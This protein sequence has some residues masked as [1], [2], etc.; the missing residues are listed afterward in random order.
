M[1]QRH[2]FVPCC[3]CGS[4]WIKPET[5]RTGD[6]HAVKCQSCGI[7]TTYHTTEAAAVRHWNRYHASEAPTKEHKP[8][9]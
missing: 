7:S 4:T 9:S 6:A 5:N 3:K 8:L 2:E 1:S